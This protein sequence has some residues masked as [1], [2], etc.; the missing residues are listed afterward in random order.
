[1]VPNTTRSNVVEHDRRIREMFAGIA[2]VYDRMN[3]LLS[4][5]FDARWRR[6]L[7]RRI[8]PAAQDL[9]DACC[10]TG[11]LL[12]TAKRMGRGRR[13]VATDFCVPMLREGIRRNG[14]G[15]QAEVLGADSQRLPFADGS[16]DAVMVGFGLRNLGD[17]PQGLREMHRVLRPGGQLLVLE[18]FRVE[19]GWLEAPVSFY[20]QRV[21]PLLGRIVGRS[22]EAY[23]YLPESM[24]RF[25]SVP[26]FSAALGQ[27]GFERLTLVET[28][29]LGI[30]HLVVAR[31]PPEPLVGQDNPATATDARI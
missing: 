21:V 12:L 19:R 15:A 7:V 13:F 28:Q 26:Q 25:V 24:G 6:N 18:F 8:H 4:L 31:R 5:G 17:L 14:L 16:F 11:E 20:L 22:S 30:A 27:A 9:L 29:T 23:R 3:G 10:G 2:G 1:M